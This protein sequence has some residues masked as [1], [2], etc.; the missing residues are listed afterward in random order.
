MSV[1]I[2]YHVITHSGYNARQQGVRL[3][4]ERVLR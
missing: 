3:R 1:P 4:T 2:Y